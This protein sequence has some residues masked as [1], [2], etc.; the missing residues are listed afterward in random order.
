MAPESAL[1]ELK[2]RAAADPAFEERSR[3]SLADRLECE[4]ELLVLW[5]REKVSRSRKKN[6]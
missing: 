5:A 1:T 3:R 6:T 2:L 4:R